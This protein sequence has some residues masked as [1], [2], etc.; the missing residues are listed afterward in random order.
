V[1]KLAVERYLS[2][3]AHAYG[4]RYTILRY[5]NVY[6]PRQDPSG[7]AGVAAI[8]ARQ[9]VREEGVAINGSG[10]QERDFVYVDDIVR[11]NRLAQDLLHGQIYN[12][13]TG[14]GTSI[15]DLFSLM[16][17][18]TRY[19]A[20]PTH[21]PPKTGE[22]FKIYLDATKARVELGWQPEVGLHEGLR[23]TIQSHQGAT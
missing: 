14:V 6:G 2:F 19:H 17:S 23:R 1:S 18:M 7:E 11:A 12:L 16:A 22:T 5:P 21:A 20:E 3:Y 8:F 4:L 10:E 9:M 15:N 13:G